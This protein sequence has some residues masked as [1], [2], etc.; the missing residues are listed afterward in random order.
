MPNINQIG[1]YKLSIG[2]H[3]Y[4]GQSINIKERLRCHLNSLKKGTHDNP[5]MQNVYF[6]HRN[7]KNFKI[8]AKVIHTLNPELYTDKEV[9]SKVLTLL[10]QTYIN[11]YKA[12]L[13]LQPA[14][15][16]NIKSKKKRKKQDKLENK[17]NVT[18][19]HALW[20]DIF[21]PDVKVFCKEKGL[22][23][24]K[25]LEVIE[26]KRVQH[27]GYFKCKEY[28]DLHKMEIGRDA[29]MY[30]LDDPYDT[31]EPLTGLALQLPLP[32]NDVDFV[33]EL[34]E[35]TLGFNPHY[36]E[37]D[38][39]WSCGAFTNDIFLRWLNFDQPELLKSLTLLSTS[40]NIVEAEEFHNL[41]ELDNLNGYQISRLIM[42]NSNIYEDY[43]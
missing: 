15:V 10:E 25:L 38:L 29:F 17:Q 5:Y 8:D 41:K 32:T 7:D 21:V 16:S 31:E 42:N 18:I 13:N 34:I 23:Y 39:P 1:I 2:T 36:T 3:T 9:L 30:P 35:E 6:K 33:N 37:E 22:N 19:H 20:G 12:D 4:I 14:A 28:L 40:P 27:K 24:R 11:Y 43:T 26:I